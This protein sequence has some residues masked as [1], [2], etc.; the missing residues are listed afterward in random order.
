M[1][2]ACEYFQL[3]V[4]LIMRRLGARGITS[5]TSA[6]PCIPPVCR[7]QQL[8]PLIFALPLPNAPRRSEHF[9][10]HMNTHANEGELSSGVSPRS[11]VHASAL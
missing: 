10:Y 6:Y 8:V 1:K 4:C 7:C 2:R 11:V 3:R 5:R 9:E